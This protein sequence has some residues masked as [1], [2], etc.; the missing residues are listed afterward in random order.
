LRC[1]T[2]E[3]VRELKPKPLHEV[4]ARVAE[5]QL[6][7]MRL[8]ETRVPANSRTNLLLDRLRVPFTYHNDRTDFGGDTRQAPLRVTGGCEIIWASFDVEP[9]SAFR[10]LVLRPARKVDKQLLPGVIC[11]CQDGAYR[12]VREHAPAVAALIQ[13]GVGVIVSEVSGTG[14]Q[15]PGGDRGRTSYATS[16]SAT[17]Q[18]LG[19]PLVGTRFDDLITLWKASVRDVGVDPEQVALWGESLA[20]PNPGSRSV[21]VPYDL[22]QPHLAEPLGATLVSLLA[23]GKSEI[24]AIVARGGLV[25]YRS[26]L[27]SPFVHVPHDALPV[28]VFRAGD[29]PDLWAHLAPKP[30]RLEGL[31]DGTNRRVTGEKLKE[32]LRPVR[33]AYPKG[34][35]V[36]AEDY[37]PDAELAKWIV[38]QLRK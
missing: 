36:V 9:G 1:W 28:N 13:A 35:L 16:L 24:K 19:K 2:E 38:E 12:F 23:L 27:E 10:G 31:V 25:S 7:R 21:A 29:L 4:L 3:A 11:V 8:G 17:A 32:A 37:S 15:Q 5:E 34:G 22:D 6:E 20:G 33:E 30:L 26:V 14:L 18:M